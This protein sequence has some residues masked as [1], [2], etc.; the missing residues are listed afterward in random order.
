MPRP[1]ASK[2][3]ARHLPGLAFTLLVLTGCATTLLAYP[4]SR[5]VLTTL[6]VRAAAI[7]STIRAAV[8]APLVAQAASAPIITRVAGSSTGSGY[9]GDDIDATSAFLRQ[10]YRAISDRAGN[11][12]IADTNNHRLVRVRPL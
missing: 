2:T 7:R 1:P 9:N 6:V 3:H 8:A 12:Y 10:P 4:S 5:T 11:I